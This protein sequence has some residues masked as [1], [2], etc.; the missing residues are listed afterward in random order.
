MELKKSYKGFVLWMI[1]FCVASFAV[2]FLPFEGL[3]LARIIQNVCSIGV[4]MLAYIIYKT[5]YIYWYTGISY[6]DAVKAGEE[7]RKEYAWKH[8]KRFG[9]FAVAY[10]IFSIVGL[11]I[12]INYWIDFAVFMVGFIGVAVSTI[13]FKL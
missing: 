7:R 3:A 8:F 1:G 10:F 4:A 11:Y 5:G 9:I 12:G 13:Q 2:V 6:E